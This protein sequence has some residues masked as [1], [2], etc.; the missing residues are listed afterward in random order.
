MNSSFFY[1]YIELN[2]F[3]TRLFWK[4]NLIYSVYIYVNVTYVNY[5]T[6][7]EYMYKINIK[8]WI[9]FLTILFNSNDND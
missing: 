9:I 8:I 6:S 4:K 2:G 1:I 3:K 5:A 7:P